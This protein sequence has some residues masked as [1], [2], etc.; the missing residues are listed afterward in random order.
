[1]TVKAFFLSLLLALT[2]AAFTAVIVLAST[3]YFHQQDKDSPMRSFFSLGNKERDI[4]YV[5]IKNLIITLRGQTHKEHYLL[6]D[7][8]FATHGDEKMKQIE[9]IMPA[10]KSTVVD[11]FSSMD[12]SAAHALPVEQ[13]R[14]DMM[15]RYKD[16]YGEKLPFDD[17]LISKMIF[18]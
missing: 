18:H 8:A 10:I 16:A 3:G 2:V 13:I 15:T 4:S 14:N 9:K 7:L 17:V 1:M 12:Y 11:M 5:E 6:L